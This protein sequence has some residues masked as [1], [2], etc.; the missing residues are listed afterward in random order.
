MEQNEMEFLYCVSKRKNV[1]SYTLKVR[2]PQKKFLMR[3][4]SLR[5][6]QK[7]CASST[8]Y[9]ASLTTLTFSR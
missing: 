3:A 9:F 1:F 7:V 5:T 8:P 6:S 4:L 2:N